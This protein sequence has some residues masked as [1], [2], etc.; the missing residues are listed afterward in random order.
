MNIHTFTLHMGLP[1]SHMCTHLALRKR[2]CAHISRI[3]ISRIF[4]SIIANMAHVVSLTNCAEM[5]TFS[6]YSNFTQLDAAYGMHHINPESF[7]RLT[8]WTRWKPENLPDCHISGDP[9]TG[10]R[11]QTRQ[12]NASMYSAF[13]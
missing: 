8:D 3:F 1:T 2:I 11:M 10:P 6:N 5:A 13:V 7:V 12:R 9:L 4:I